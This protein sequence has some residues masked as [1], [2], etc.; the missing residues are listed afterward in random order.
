MLKLSMLLL[1]L[2]LSYNNSAQ[3]IEQN[4]VVSSGK[5]RIVVGAK[6]TDYRSP[7][8]LQV[9]SNF[10]WQTKLTRLLPLGRISKIIPVNVSSMTSGAYALLLQ[11]TQGSGRHSY[12][13]FEIYGTTNN[14]ASILSAQVETAKKEFDLGR[15]KLVTQNGNL[16]LAIAEAQYNC[17]LEQ[18]PMCQY[19]L[20]PK[21]A[22]VTTIKTI[23]LSYTQAELDARMANG[24]DTLKDAEKK[25]SFPHL[26]VDS[27]TASSIGNRL[28]GSLCSY[29]NATQINCVSSTSFYV[30]I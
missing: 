4:T 11:R 25:I 29:L 5:L 24:W 3:A 30:E 21:A 8:Y 7:V 13:I 23:P 27:F 17:S 20:P 14:G 19:N 26:R 6:G 10:R 1:S 28:Y 22:V 12:D 18:D 16:V 9:Y 15:Y 2:F